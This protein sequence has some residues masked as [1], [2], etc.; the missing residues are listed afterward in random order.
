MRCV[1][2]VLFAVYTEFSF[3][4]VSCLA[5]SKLD[6]FFREND[7]GPIKSSFV[8]TG[9]EIEREGNDRRNM[10][11]PGKQLQLLQDAVKYGGLVSMETAS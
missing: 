4:L 2:V 8:I 5:L 3:E 11:L 7:L 1:S 9:T 10:E 6:K